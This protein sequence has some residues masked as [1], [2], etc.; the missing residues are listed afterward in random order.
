VEVH[1]LDFSGQIYGEE[2]M[3]TFAARLRTEMK[4]ASIADLRKQIS[5]DVATARKLMGPSPRVV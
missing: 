1:L 5:C 4:F 3:V 2:M